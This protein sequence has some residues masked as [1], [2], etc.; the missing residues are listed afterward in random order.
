LVSH[1]F[2]A[3]WWVYGAAVLVILLL[4]LFSHRRIDGAPGFEMRPRLLALFPLFV[5]LNGAA[6][7]LGLKTE[8]TF[9]MFSNLRT[10]A[11]YAN[12]LI[13]DGGVRLVD[14]QDDLVYMESSSDE[15]LSRL[16]KTGYALPYFE[17][18]SY[19]SRKVRAGTAG[20]EPIRITYVRG[21]RRVDVADA[22]RERELAEPDR[23]LA[24]KLLWF[25]PVFTGVSPPCTH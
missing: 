24:R 4:L 21:D 6:P 5:L 7:Y 8:N 20:S 19:V 17:F 9:S 1:G 14:Y 25:R 18:R 16:A 2:E 11:G 22:A 23:W 15:E 13:L 10:E 12:H 3:L